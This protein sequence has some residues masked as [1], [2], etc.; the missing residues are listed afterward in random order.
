MATAV[1]KETKKVYD[2]GEKK[3]ENI[4]LFVNVM[5]KVHVHLGNANI[6]FEN[7]D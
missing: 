3:E 1:K 5:Y 2:F 4:K 7:L 6:I